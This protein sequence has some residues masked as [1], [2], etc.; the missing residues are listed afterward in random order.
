MTAEPRP[1]VP[2][3]DLR[4]QLKA[5][6]YL[7]ARVDRF[8]LG[9]A[10]SGSA[11]RLALAA[12]LRI[13]ALAG[14]LLGPAAAAG[15]SARLPGL[16]TSLADAVVLACYLAVLMGAGSA[17]L[18]FVVTLAA[19]ALARKAASQP[20]F[21]MRARRA[22]VMAGLVVAALCLL[23]LTLWWR[24]TTL[25][26]LEI[27][28]GPM[29]PLGGT[30]AQTLVLAIAVAI[31][32]LIGHS[33]TVTV[34]AT[35]VRSGLARSLPQGSPLS[36]WRVLLPVSAVAL[37]GA[38]S[39]L[40][41][42]A[43]AAS[44]TA[45]PSPLV[46]V[47]T[48]LRVVV[49]AIDGVDVATLS[50]LI[51]AG[52][53]PTLEALTSQ[54]RAPLANDADRDPARVWTTIAT[55]QPPERHGIRALEARQLAGVEGRLR[56]ESPALAVLTAAT[57][58]L[59]LTRPAIA[60]GDERVL[61]A[62]WEVAAAA[63]LRTAVIHWW[64]TW[65]A[66]DGQGVVVSDRAILR[67]EQ[68]GA[69]AGEIAPAS[70]YDS[71]LTGADARRRRVA[72]ATSRTWPAGLPDDVTSTLRRSAELDATVLD[73]GADAA[74]GPLDLLTVYLPGLDIAQHALLQGR[75]GSALAPSAMADRVRGLEAY[76]TFLDAALATWLSARPE[77]DQQVVLVMQ[78]GRVQQPSAG[79][80]AVSGAS[81]ASA[82]VADVSPTVVAPTVLAALGVPVASDL[83]GA[84]ARALF[85]EEFQRKHP[86][87]LVATY[88]E[89]RRSTQPRT[90][91]P[92]DQEM[93]ERMRSLG[94]VR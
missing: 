28:S 88:G 59:R 37:V 9:R 34:L 67:L 19:G 27:G 80:L 1:S 75:D 8:V 45:A 66:T 62:F 36:S 68:G 78:P 32:V 83:A 25:A 46:V 63:G 87:R 54:A 4:E 17:L 81:A 24:A 21:P 86:E 53:T 33:V 42:T 82:R 23:Y 50:R 16:V 11:G 40:A 89:R 77:A 10:P 48:G 20:D 44:P 41:A 2:V 26:T 22:A 93:I 60:S 51:A 12:S 71:L 90:G 73:L 49:V 58:V 72:A 30:A 29:A 35:L 92:L 5:L 56:S 84:A 65:P 91:Q 47:P 31:S 15:L 57:D 43:P 85:S 52:A 64:A 14:A 61:P 39:L 55:A 76:Y 70:V 94:Y 7:D 74:L 79:L 3:D 6:G 13:G 18:A 38:F 69:L